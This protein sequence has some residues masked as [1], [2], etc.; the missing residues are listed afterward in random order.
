MTPLQ[1]AEKLVRNHPANK[2]LKSKT[3]HL[4]FEQHD[5]GEHCS[6]CVDFESQLYKLDHLEHYLKLLETKMEH[7]YVDSAGSCENKWSGEKVC[8]FNLTTGRPAS[9]KDAEEFIRLIK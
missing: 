7:Y 3:K 5:E 2:E 9:E 6:D 4:W 8:Q 1:R